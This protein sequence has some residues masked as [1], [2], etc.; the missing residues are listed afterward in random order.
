MTRLYSK[1]KNV[2]LHQQYMRIQ[3]SVA[4]GSWVNVLWVRVEGYN[5]PLDRIKHQLVEECIIGSDKS[6]NVLVRY[7]Q[8]HLKVLTHLSDHL[9]GSRDK[10]I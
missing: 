2:T 3:S 9:A 1:Y 8:I 6:L 10:S 7:K 4:E 5:L